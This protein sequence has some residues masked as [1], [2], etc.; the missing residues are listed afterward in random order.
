MHQDA[1]PQMPC[2]YTISYHHLAPSSL[3]EL[4][5]LPQH[6]G[7]C[8]PEIVEEVCSCT[9][10]YH[11]VSRKPF[12][13]LKMVSIS[14]TTRLFWLVVSPAHKPHRS[15]FVS[16]IASFTVAG[17]SSGHLSGHPSHLSPEEAAESRLD[18]VWIMCFLLVAMIID[19]N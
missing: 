5:C 9:R 6:Y 13:L 15:L 1:G 7:S 3:F 10:K 18:H 14:Q 4:A 16:K 19:I 11:K 8:R 12:E 2:C 17:D